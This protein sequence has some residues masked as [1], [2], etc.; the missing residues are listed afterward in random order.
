MSVLTIAELKSQINS[1]IKSNHNKEITGPIMN[2]QLN[3][4]I[5]N[6][7]RLKNRIYKQATYP[8]SSDLRTNDI[9]FKTDTETLEV[10]NGLTWDIIPLGGDTTNLVPYTGANQNVDLGNNDLT[11]SGSIILPNLLGANIL[12]TD[13]LGNVISNGLISYFDATVGDVTTYAS[14]VA[15]TT[16]AIGDNVK[17]GSIGY[18]SLQSGNLGN[19][20][21]SSPLFW[22]V[23]NPQF[24][25]IQKALAAGKYNLKIVADTIETVNWGV[26]STPIVIFG[27]KLRTINLSVASTSVLTISATNINFSLTGTNT[28]FAGGTFYLSNCTI[29]GDNNHNVFSSFANLFADYL[30]INAG[31]NGIQIHIRYANRLD[32]STSNNGL[33]SQSNIIIIGNI[34]YLSVGGIVTNSTT[35]YLILIGSG[36]NINYVSGGNVATIRIDGYSQINSGIAIPRLLFQNNVT[37]QIV[38]NCTIATVIQYAINGSPIV[39]DEMSNCI[40]TSLINL[41]GTAEMSNFKVF[42]NNTL[43]NA[44][45]VVGN[46][47]IDESTFNGVFTVTGNATIIKSKML[48]TTTLNADNI[49]FENNTCT[50]LVTLQAGSDNCIINDNTFNGGYSYTLGVVTNEYNNN[51]GT[52]IANQTNQPQIFNDTVTIADF[53]PATPAMVES[54]STGLLSATKE[55]VSQFIS[56]ATIIALLVDPTHWTG[57]N[58]TFATPITLTF[59]GQ[60]HSDASYLFLAVADNSWIRIARA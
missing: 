51:K 38:R 1:V 2:T 58:Y 46:A 5:D 14:Y 59:Q 18:V 32:I 29:T 6:I 16:Y 43:T 52:V 55:L 7:D 33:N 47:N 25:K 49:T 10:Y 56:N 37:N 41:A 60:M 20:P 22:K 36:G 11:V 8:S 26:H 42:K 12:G 34:G 15:G 13:S 19:T 27:D 21:A 3:D 23:V 28:I 40:I 48:S 4:V 50:G 17:D 44:I 30:I 45:T 53:N 35:N 54:S 39:L 24:D 57:V 31:N 9:L